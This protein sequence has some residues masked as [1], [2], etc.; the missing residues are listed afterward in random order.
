MITEEELLQL[1]KL[2]KKAS[3]GPWSD[4]NWNTIVHS[5]TEVICVVTSVNRSADNLFII[6]ARNLLPRLLKEY[7]E[8]NER[9]KK[10]EAITEKTQNDLDNTLNKVFELQTQLSHKDATIAKMR[11]TLTEIAESGNIPWTDIVSPIE[12]ELQDIRHA[13]KMQQYI[14]R[15]CLKEV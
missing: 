12:E 11:K 6:S 2:E 3:P 14:A 9:L 10:W 4:E 13:F 8:Q 15:Q 1:E 5:I 7:R